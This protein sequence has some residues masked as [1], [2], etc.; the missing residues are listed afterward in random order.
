MLIVYTLKLSFY[1]LC[2]VESLP[3]CRDH[4]IEEPE[5]VP[6]LTS[7]RI[8]T[9]HPILNHLPFLSLVWIT[10]TRPST[11]SLPP[12]PCKSELR[13]SAYVLCEPKQVDSVSGRPP[14]WKSAY[15]HPRDHDSVFHTSVPETWS[16]SCPESSEKAHCMETKIQS[17]A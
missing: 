8:I 9:V 5:N 11:A 15:L 1:H 12:P 4:L 7:F 6:A 17:T 14:P 2:R 16:G 3:R 13:S 10:W